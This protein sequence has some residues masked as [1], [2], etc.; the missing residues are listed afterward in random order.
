MLRVIFSLFCPVIV[1]IIIRVILFTLAFVLALF[2]KMFNASKEIKELI[3]N[4]G[5][6]ET[7]IWNDS[8]L[9]WGIV[10]IIVFIAEVWIWFPDID[11]QNGNPGTND[12]GKS[13]SQLDLNSNQELQIGSV[14]NKGTSIV[15]VECKK[16]IPSESKYCP[17]CGCDLYVTCPQCG[18][19]YL[20]LYPICNEC[21]T[22]RNEWNQRENER[23][24]NKINASINEWRKKYEENPEIFNQ[25]EGLSAEDQIAIRLL[26]SNLK[27][28]ERQRRE[29]KLRELSTIYIL[30]DERLALWITAFGF[31]ICFFL[32]YVLNIF[33]DSRVG[34]ILTTIFFTLILMMISLWILHLI[35]IATCNNIFGLRDY[36]SEK[37]G[38][39]KLKIFIQEHPDDIDIGYLREKLNEMTHNDKV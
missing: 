34:R 8:Y 13:E 10:V 27:N 24:Q 35:N 26:K 17:Y 12:G 23:N 14:A 25:E 11:T 9:Y 7:F 19:K 21:G 37:R 16:T 32:V 29:E 6:F 20:N 4:I 38:Y 22:N 31:I 36:I 15:C 2:G 39:K 30:V 18:H 1:A 28:E 3:D 5:F 33:D